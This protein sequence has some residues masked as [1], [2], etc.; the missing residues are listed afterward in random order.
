MEAIVLRYVIIRGTAE[1][2]L[3]LRNIKDLSARE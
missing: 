3:R 2:V 1:E